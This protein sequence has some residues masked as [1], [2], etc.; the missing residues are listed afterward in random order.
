[1]IYQ[2]INRRNDFPNMKHL[3]TDTTFLSHS[4]IMFGATTGVNIINYLFHVIM[5]RSLGPADYGILGAL[6]S[7]LTI[8][9]LITLPIYNVV[10]KYSAQYSVTNKLWIVNSFLRR[11]WGIALS[12]GI[13]ITLAAGLLS[14][15]FVKW[16][17]LPSSKLVWMLG[18]AT[19]FISLVAV[20]RG[21]LQGIQ[22]FGAL[23]INM[24]FESALKFF[25]GVFFVWQGFS[26]GG[27]VSGVGLGAGLAWIASIF[28]LRSVIGSEQRDRTIF[29]WKDISQYFGAAF[30]TLLCF[31]ALTNIDVIVARRL[32]SAD[33]AGFYTAVSTLSKI[34][35]YF[36]GAIALVVFPKSTQEYTLGRSGLTV[37]WQGF[38]AVAFLS[39]AIVL[40]FFLIPKVLVML[41]FGEAFLAIAPL[42]GWLGIG[43]SM[44]GVL[45]VLM[46]YLLSV[47]NRILPW[48][49]LAGLA[50]EIVLLT[51][52]P[53]TTRSLIAIVSFIGL[54]L[55]IVG[56]LLSL[57]S[58][59]NS[60]I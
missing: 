56:I 49:M 19:I 33:Q 11:S 3:F 30:V 27:A 5:S 13:I 10:A 6:L 15:R 29:P 43:M 9:S 1:M 52:I 2:Q 22:A 48:V 32:L 44:Y 40:I 20:N 47:E 46:Y 42:I 51:S 16:F 23:G 35:L 8:L 4:V 50:I 7:M 14:S 53:Q 17:I 41:L 12:Y 18:I 34:I 36:P 58:T 45:R 60:Q 26:V 25:S 39:C 38:T 57:R 31:T 55:M 21:T 28:P 24:I 37:I 54:G 59:Q